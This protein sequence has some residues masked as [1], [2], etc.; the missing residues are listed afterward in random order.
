M[1]Y[2]IKCPRYLAQETS[3]KQVIHPRLN[4]RSS[5]YAVL[6]TSGRV[7]YSTSHVRV[8]LHTLSGNASLVSWPIQYCIARSCFSA[9]WL[10]LA[11]GCCNWLT[12]HSHIHISLQAIVTQPTTVK[13]TTTPWSSI[14]PL[15]RL[16]QQH[17]IL[18]IQEVIGI[19]MPNNICHLHSHHCLTCILVATVSTTASTSTS[20]SSNP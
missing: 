20:T 8:S 19:I 1:Q 4:Q 6:V 16:Q 15:P 3:P 10:G 17:M 13:N 5:F 14:N 7:A 18:L 11:R 12:P 9:V 2:R